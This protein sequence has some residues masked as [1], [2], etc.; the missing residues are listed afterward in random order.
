MGE[1][2]ADI[3]LTLRKPGCAAGAAA[4]AQGTICEIDTLPLAINFPFPCLPYLTGSEGTALAVSPQRTPTYNT[5][6]REH[7]GMIALRSTEYLS[8]GTVSLD[9]SC[10]TGLEM[11]QL[12]VAVLGIFM[13]GHY[14]FR[15]QTKLVLVQVLHTVRYVKLLSTYLTLPPT[16]P[17]DR[18]ISGGGCGQKSVS[19]AA[20]DVILRHRL[21]KYVPH[22]RYRSTSDAI[23]DL[24]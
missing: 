11:P 9:R 2:H 15:C 20:V 19:P 6:I 14:Y 7:D 21:Y 10:A 12:P 17:T 13:C 1:V 3:S 18:V 22:L 23:C 5:T 4:A 8:K 16:G 24:A